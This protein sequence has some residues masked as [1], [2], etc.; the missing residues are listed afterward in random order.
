[1]DE[2]TPRNSS[3]HSEDVLIVGPGRL[4]RSLLGALRSLGLDVRIVGRG[5]AIPAA[6]LTLLTVP[7]RAIAE[8]AALCPPG[9]V[10]LHTSGAT[11]V[12]ALRPHAPAGCLHPLMSF[13]D[14]SQR[15]PRF[16]GVPASVSGDPE[17]RAAGRWLAE[18]LGMVPFELSGD[19]RLYHAAAVMAGNFATALLAEAAAVLSAAGVPVEQAPA[20]LAPLA[21]ASIENAASIGPA[22]ALTGPVARGDE[23]VIEAHREALACATPE[24]LTTYDALLAAA[25]R[26]RE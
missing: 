24:Q 21:L 23:A 11:P 8:V 17:A 22:R 20:L 26:L 9:G 1:M 3:F 13:P 15:P 18:L 14:P 6:E 7:D 2:S 4:G 10:L 25:R 12:D 19:R 16:A 5:S